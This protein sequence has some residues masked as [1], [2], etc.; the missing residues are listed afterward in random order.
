M[1]KYGIP[2]RATPRNIWPPLSYSK[3]PVVGGDAVDSQEISKEEEAR[4]RMIAIEA[5]R[6]GIS[7]EELRRR[8]SMAEQLSRDHKES[9]LTSANTNG[10]AWCGLRKLILGLT[11]ESA[12]VRHSTGSPS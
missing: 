10:N 3:N 12:T 7:I 2:A 6:R 1:A 5:Q 9:M 4:R 11:T 8:I